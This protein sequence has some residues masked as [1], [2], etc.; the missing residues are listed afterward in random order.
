IRDD[1]VD[2]AVGQLGGGGVAAGQVKG[3]IGEPTIYGPSFLDFSAERRCAWP[4]L[5]GPGPIDLGGG[6]PVVDRPQQAAAEEVGE[7]AR[8]LGRAPD[9]GLDRRPL[10]LEDVVREHVA[11]RTR[12]LALVG[13]E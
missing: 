12:A 6:E 10:R 1:E 5:G 11:D 7:G 13:C 4:A 3:A 2:A 9:V 8:A